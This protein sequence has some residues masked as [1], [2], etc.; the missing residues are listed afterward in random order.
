MLRN[1]PANPRCGLGSRGSV[2]I[3]PRPDRRTEEE[4]HDLEQHR[5]RSFGPRESRLRWPS[6][7]IE[8]DLQVSPQDSGLRRR[9]FRKRSYLEISLEHERD[10]PERYP[11][12][13][14]G[15]I[16]PA[17]RSPVDQ[18]KVRWRVGNDHHVGRLQVSM[19]ES[20]RERGEREGRQK[21]QPPRKPASL[22]GGEVSGRCQ[23][24]RH[25][26]R[27]RE[28]LAFETRYRPILAHSLVQSGEVPAH[29]VPDPGDIFGTE[30]KHTKR[31]SMHPLVDRIRYRKE[32]K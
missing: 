5:R 18:G 31:L 21:I 10:R 17:A 20:P 4:A 3:R 22:L 6:E 11:G 28:R 27:V 24:V 25:R 2:K 1:L 9:I 12:E 15:R 7:K 23:L 16:P 8:G 30:V 26:P 29:L 32:L 19:T 13:I 14:M